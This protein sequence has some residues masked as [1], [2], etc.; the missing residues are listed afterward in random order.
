M[1]IPAAIEQLTTYRNKQL[2]L[3]SRADDATW[4]K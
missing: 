2:S 4:Q 3:L 1:D